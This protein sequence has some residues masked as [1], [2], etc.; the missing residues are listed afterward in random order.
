MGLLCPHGPVGPSCGALA[1]LAGSP[2]LAAVAGSWGS[3]LVSS[4]WFQ[5]RGSTCLDAPSV[6]VHLA[7]ECLVV[8][9]CGAATYTFFRRF[10]RFSSLHSC[11]SSWK[12]RL[13]AGGTSPGPSGVLWVVCPNMAG[14]RHGPGASCSPSGAPAVPGCVAGRLGGDVVRD[15]LCSLVP[16]LAGATSSCCSGGSRLRYSS[17]RGHWVSVSYLGLLLTWHTLWRSVCLFR[18]CSFRR[19]GHSTGQCVRLL[20][21]YGGPHRWSFYHVSAVTSGVFYSPVSGSA[22][23]GC[24]RLAAAEGRSESV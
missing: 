5:L 22:N 15:L 14:P 7:R 6:P 1:S 12:P 4:L 11:A 24:G 9:D 18:G 13:R 23:L 19:G 10:H 17:E 21:V 3:S 16:P 2:V 8:L 20:G